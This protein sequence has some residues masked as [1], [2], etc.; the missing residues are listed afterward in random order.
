MVVETKKQ[1]KGTLW[2][3]KNGSFAAYWFQLNS[4]GGQN[5][6]IGKVRCRQTSCGAHL[7]R[8]SS[9]K[10]PSALERMW[11]N[12]KL[13]SKVWVESGSCSPLQCHIIRSYR[14]VLS[15]GYAVPRITSWNCDFGIFWD[16]LRRQHWDIFDLQ[17]NFEGLHLPCHACYVI[18]YPILGMIEFD[19]QIW[20]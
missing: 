19:L 6:I 12:Q 17:G 1:Q 18:L 5:S 20:T 2:P 13:P 10:T 11:P 4:Y 9:W 15:H 8:T 16:S 3:G 14:T 7:W